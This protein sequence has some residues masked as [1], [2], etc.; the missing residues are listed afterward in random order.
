MKM[1][2]FKDGSA[3]WPST[4]ERVE[5]ALGDLG[6]AEV[7]V[8]RR[9]SP[10]G[11]RLLIATDLG[12][13]E[14]NRPLDMQGEPTDKP[15]EVK[16]NPW[17]I[18]DGISLTGTVEKGW[19]DDEF[20]GGLGVAWTLDLQGLGEF[21]DPTQVNNRPE[22]MQQRRMLLD[23]TRE[24]LRQRHRRAPSSGGET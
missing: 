21:K 15:V 23:F 5:R 4:I 8:L 2:E 17:S 7:A 20:A 6:L 24:L 13:V 22:W 3:W 9:S 14:C 18:V 12:L 11:Y 16:V 1:A 19:P 10:E